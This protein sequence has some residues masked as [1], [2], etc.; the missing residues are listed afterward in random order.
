M[1][2][3]GINPAGLPH[4][5]T[6][7]SIRVCRSPRS[8]AACRVLPRRRKPRHPPSALLSFHSVNRDAHGALADS[9]A[10]ALLFRLVMKLRPQRPLLSLKKKGTT[11]LA[12][13][14]L[15]SVASSFVLYFSCPTCSRNR[16]TSL[17]FS[18]IVKQLSHGPLAAG[19]FAVLLK[20]KA[21]G[22]QPALA[23]PGFRN[24][25]SVPAVT[26]IRGHAPK[27]RCSSHTF[28]Y[29]YLVTT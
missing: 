24:D 6:R 4:S 21:V 8:F 11:R 16:A 26:A 20:E 1:S 7:G 19:P 14:S 17:I 22:K 15:A 5:D 27:R 2:G 29:G 10:T 25:A 12:M 9:S 18:S 3:D 13:L 28:R 23:T